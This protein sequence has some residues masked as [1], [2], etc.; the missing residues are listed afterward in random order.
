ELALQG[1]PAPLVLGANVLLAS[2][3]T[4][5]ITVSLRAPA[6][7]GWVFTAGEG[8]TAEIVGED[9][10]LTG[11]ASDLNNWLGSGDKLKWNGDAAAM[12]ITAT[13]AGQVQARTSFNIG[14]ALDGLLDLKT[15]TAPVLGASATRSDTLQ[16]SGDLTITDAWLSQRGLTGGALKLQ[17]SGAIVWQAS[18]TKLASV[19]LRAGGS[20]QIQGTLDAAQANLSAAT[21]IGGAGLVKANQLSLNTGNGD[22]GSA[23]AALRID[24]Q[25]SNARLGGQVRGAAYISEASDSLMLDRLRVSGLA[26]L[27]T[28]SG[29]I[30]GVS[31]AGFADLQ[32]A[33]VAL[34]SS[35]EIGATSDALVLSTASLSASG[36]GRVLIDTHGAVS[37]SSLAVT[38]TG[39]VASVNARGNL[40]LAGSVSSSGSLSLN[41]RGEI[42]QGASSTVT[43]AG[44]FSMSSVRGN[45]TQAAGASLSAVGAT[46]D[47]GAGMALGS[48]NAGSGL[49]SLTA[50]AGSI[51]DADTTDNLDLSGGSVWISASESIG[52]NLLAGGLVA[53]GGLAP[54]ALDINTATISAVAAGGLRLN[55]AGSLTVASISGILGLHSTDGGDIALNVAGDR[56]TV[57]GQVSVVAGGQVAL[58]VDNA[59]NTSVLD[60]TGQVRAEEG[61]VQLAADASVNLVA[62]GSPP[63]AMS[64]R[65]RTAG[66]VL[67]TASKGLRIVDTAGK[68]APGS[69]GRSDSPGVIRIVGNQTIA[70]S[71][72]LA[73]QISGEDD[74]QSDQLQVTGTLTVSD[75]SAID[76]ELGQGVQPRLG[77]SYGLI[78]AGTVVGHFD[79]GTG[80]FGFDDGSA[81][82]QLNAKSSGIPSVENSLSLQVVQRPGAD[83]DALKI[84]AHSQADKD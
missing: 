42:T 5:P 53:T 35:A 69:F 23:A 67:I 56:L 41:S 39:A 58:S 57:A 60:I 10:V 62:A 33:S 37:V 4:G 77:R 48:V 27:S 52:E 64:D 84:T 43:A 82:L 40:A 83:A 55:S 19:D 66:D 79:S 51:L 46:L 75:G 13:A 2:G 12:Q 47:A 18:T 45:I 30:L 36:V 28:V 80:L 73:L 8:V 31:Q 21:S 78:E 32:A 38:G 26:S 25:G 24:L 81:L 63:L 6:T 59:A 50:R 70:A 11:S 34:V 15:G 9:L 71:Q 68:D 65:I 20:L 3:I 49:L 44:A 74:D 16:V 22:V 29:G 14:S 17:A 54:N 7:A 72:R 1:K 76:I 61:A